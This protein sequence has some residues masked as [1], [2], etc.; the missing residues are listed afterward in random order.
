VT[1]AE[2][3]FA[4][5]VRDVA[6]DLLAY[7]AR[8]VWPTEDAADCVAE[9]MVVLWRRRS[10]LPSEPD[11][12]RAWSFGVARGVLQNYRRAGARRLALADAV[13]SAVE[14]RQVSSSGELRAELVTALASLKEV[15]RELVLLVAWEG[16]TVDA[17]AGVLG[18]K[19]P[20]ARARYSRA[21]AKLRSVLEA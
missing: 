16:L 14:A 18:I 19:A 1:A 7:C 5:Y 10:E 8:R 11:A 3:D 15:D 21:R 4:D 20:A 13:R 12:A 9:T 6:P 2:Q 17:A